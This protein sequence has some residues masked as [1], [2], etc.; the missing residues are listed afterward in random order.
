MEAARYNR[1]IV[2]SGVTHHYPPP[3]YGEHLV[4]ILT[5]YLIVNEINGNE[6]KY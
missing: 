1:T 4:L 5:N 3:I 2:E 6:N